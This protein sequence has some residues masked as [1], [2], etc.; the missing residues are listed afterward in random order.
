MTDPKFAI[1]RKFLQ[2]IKECKISNKRTEKRSM[3][4]RNNESLK[5]KMGAKKNSKAVNAEKKKDKEQSLKFMVSM[6]REDGDAL[7]DIEESS[8]SESQLNIT[9][10]H[11]SFEKSPKFDQPY[12]V[13]KQESHPVP[14]TTHIQTVGPQNPL[15]LIKE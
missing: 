13:T 14:I 15:V 2:H 10:N 6:M 11:L 9:N 4:D 7:S 12:E 3:I 8:D 5:Q 1:Y